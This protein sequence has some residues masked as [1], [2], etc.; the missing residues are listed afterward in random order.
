MH[1]NIRS[2]LGLQRHAIQQM[3]VVT[4]RPNDLQAA[5]THVALIQQPGLY[6]T[7]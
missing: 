3:Y 4:H 2:V 1:G 7:R 5:D 6:T